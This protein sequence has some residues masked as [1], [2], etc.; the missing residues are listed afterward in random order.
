MK[1]TEREITALETYYEVAK[2]EYDDTHAY[3]DGVDNKANIFIAISV[4]VPSILL[5]IV[6]IPPGVHGKIVFGSFVLGIVMLVCVLYRIY[7]AL[8]IRQAIF[9]PPLDDF[10]EACKSYSN[11]AIR[12]AIADAWLRAAKDMHEKADRKAAELRRVQCPLFLEVAF[13]L[14]GAIVALAYRL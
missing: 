13:L 3:Y 6:E 7:Q 14:G 4:V 5:S 11:E 12:E 2:K 10:R 9:G 8:R 1:T